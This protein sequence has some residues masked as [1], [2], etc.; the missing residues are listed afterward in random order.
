MDGGLLF[1]GVPLNSDVL[2]FNA[3]R[4]YG[5]ARLPLLTANWEV[6]MK[7]EQAACLFAV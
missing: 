6:R 2:A 3:H 4:L 1:L 7:N 5:P